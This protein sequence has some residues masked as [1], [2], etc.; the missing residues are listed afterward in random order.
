[1]PYTVK[2]LS[3]LS[4]VTVRTLHFYEE[5][6][7]L[8]PA[9]K[10]SNGYRYYEEKELLKLQQILFFKKLGFTLKQI[11]K[12]LG[13]SDFNHLDALYSHKQA[14]SRDWKKMRLLIKTID[15]TIKHLEGK[16]KMKESEMFEGLSLVTRGKGNE[17]YF[18][19]EE[20][21]LKSVKKPNEKHEK[22]YYEDLDRTAKSIFKDLVRLQGQGVRSGSEEVQQVIR[23][24]HAFISKQQNANRDVYEALALLYIEHPEFRKQLDQFDPKLASFMSQAMKIFA[25]KKL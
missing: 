12:T 14:L 7:L 18:A 16:K 25:E 17:S 19:A 24:H 9:Y 15:K 21:V 1:M 23:K 13:Q 3:Q 2:E 5:L 22:A 4:G 6:N 8:K 10:G 20:L 11:Q